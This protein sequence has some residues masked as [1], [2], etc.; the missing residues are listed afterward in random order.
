MLQCH[1]IATSKKPGAAP[2][3]HLGCSAINSVL[4]R[5]RTTSII[6]VLY[7]VKEVHLQQIKFTIF[8]GVEHYA[9]L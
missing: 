9:N 7:K 5:A 1:R 3:S 8:I 2:F 4:F 6:D